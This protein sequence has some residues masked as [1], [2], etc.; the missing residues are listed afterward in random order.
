MTAINRL[1]SVALVGSTFLFSGWLNAAVPI[2]RSQPDHAADSGDAVP[3]ARNTGVQAADQ[4]L[5]ETLLFQIQDLQRTVAEQR[6]LIEELNYQ[7]QILQQEQKERYLDLD[8]RILSVQEQV[9]N[10]PSSV[11]APTTT[12]VSAVALSDEAILAQY[13]AAR[14]L[15]RERKFDE[16]IADLTVFANQHSQHPLTPSAWFWI[17]E[18]YLVQR[19]NANAQTA[20]ERI[21]DT[22]PDNERVPDSLYKLGVI[23][24][25]S[26]QL[27]RAKELYERVI[28]DY[29]NSQSAKLSAARLNSQ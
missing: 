19:D 6:G 12:P 22:Y 29:P 16:A 14:D 26:N 21:V 9:A 11:A 23:A 18:I 25:Q 2:I 27:D 3:I 28:A 7:V 1:I 24:Q 15:M 4:A 17:G 10:A 20:F 5:L 13:N 8:R